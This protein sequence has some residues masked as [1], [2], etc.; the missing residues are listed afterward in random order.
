MTGNDTVVADRHHCDE[1]QDCESGSCQTI[2]DKPGATRY[3]VAEPNRG[4]YA[5]ADVPESEG[6]C[7]EDTDCQ[8][9]EFAGYCVTSSVGYCGG[10]RPPEAN[11]CRY[12][13]CQTDDDCGAEAI[14][15]P[16]GYPHA[17]HSTNHCV[18]AKCSVDGDCTSR[19]G[20]QCNPLYSA[21]DCYGVLG[22]ICTYDDAACRGS[23]DC[24]TGQVCIADGD[25]VTC[26]APQPVG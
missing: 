26:M 22:F 2:A 15:A 3:C 18:F 5:C 24:P 13:E 16:A 8:A 4:H 11:G 25:S 21:P 12:D 23:D 6:G 1:D 14:C 10:M 9:D 19:S 7:C 20:G 17:G